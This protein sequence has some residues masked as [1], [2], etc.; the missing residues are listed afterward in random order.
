MKGNNPITNTAP[1]FTST[2]ES[3]N[4]NFY[5]ASIRGYGN[6]PDI[7]NNNY[8][9]N[10]QSNPLIDNNSE[11]LSSF[12]PKNYMN[13]PNLAAKGVK[14]PSPV[15][16]FSNYYLNNP[17]PNNIDYGY[18]KKKTFLMKDYYRNEKP[19]RDEFIK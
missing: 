18:S 19:D 14:N 4:N 7:N 11:F 2:N 16:V 12:N 9:L 6:N 8:N 5:S 1:N 13:N 15:K 17:D 3:N 10:S